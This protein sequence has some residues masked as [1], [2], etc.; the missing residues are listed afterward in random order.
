[1]SSWLY[2]HIELFLYARLWYISVCIFVDPQI[3][4]IEY[5]HLPLV[6]D[7]PLPLNY[8]GR[9]LPVNDNVRRLGNPKSFATNN[10][11]TIQSTLYTPCL[12]VHAYFGIVYYSCEVENECRLRLSKVFTT[13]RRGLW[14]KFLEGRD[15]IQRHKFEDKAKGSKIL[16]PTLGYQGVSFHACG[17]RGS[18][19]GDC[20]FA[21]RW[22]KDVFSLFP[23]S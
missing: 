9:V 20:T 14:G 8:I 21:E 6:S 23:I 1:M 19:W 2:F 18:S 17:Q 13:I 12:Q 22:T 15:K 11:G 3:I 5:T 10:F 4:S 7:F 16:V